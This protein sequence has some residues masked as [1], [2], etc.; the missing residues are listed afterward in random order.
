MTEAL[1]KLLHVCWVA[2]RFVERCTEEERGMNTSTE[3]VHNL[4][5]M[6]KQYSMSGWQLCPQ[7]IFQMWVGSTSMFCFGPRWWNPI[8]FVGV[9]WFC[10]CSSY[11]MLC[12]PCT[13]SKL[14]WVMTHITLC[15]GNFGRLHALTWEDGRIEIRDRLM[16][17]S[18]QNLP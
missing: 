4:M 16:G 3:R 10:C 7:T 11:T 9:Y 18:D 6:F 1:L 14:P 12:R 15:A 2:G 17:H 5:K 8:P 13:P